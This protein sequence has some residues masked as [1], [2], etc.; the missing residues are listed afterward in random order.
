MADET[1]REAYLIP[2]AEMRRTQVKAAGNIVML[3][4]TINYYY[5]DI[6]NLSNRKN[7]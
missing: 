4:I 2:A 3:L 6:N 5:L 7:R 1:K